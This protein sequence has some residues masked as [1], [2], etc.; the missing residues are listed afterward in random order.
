M[1]KPEKPAEVSTSIFRVVQAV[2]AKG[3]PIPG[4]WDCVELVVT[5]V[6]TKRVALESAQGLPVCRETWRRQM[7]Q[8]LE[9]NPEDQPW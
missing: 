8:R 1:A 7:M 3:K 4:K 6:V 5:G 9:A 2:D